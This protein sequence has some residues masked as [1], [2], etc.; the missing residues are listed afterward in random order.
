MGIWSGVKDFFMGKPAEQAPGQFDPSAFGLGSMDFLRQQFQSGAAGAQGRGAPMAGQ[1]QINQGPQGEVRGRE[2]ALADQLTGVSTGQQMGAGELAVR[3]QMAQALAG[4]QAAQRMARGSNAAIGARAAARAAGDMGVNAAGMSAQQALADQAAAR[5]QLGGLLGGIRGADLG[6]ATSQAGLE[7]QTNLANQGASLQ[8]RGMNDALQLG[9]LGG[10]TDAERAQMQG[11]MGL[12]GLRLSPGQQGYLG[13]ILQMGGQL[14]GAAIMMS[15]ERVKENVE[16][17]RAAVREFL[18]K[19]KPATWDYKDP[20]HGQGRHAGVMA[21][22]VEKSKLGKSIVQETPDGKALDGKK[23][24][25]ATLAAA[26]DLNAR[27]SKLESKKKTA[28]PKATAKKRKA[29]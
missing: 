15:D 21:Q 7:Q 25:S 26:V 28:L 16:D 23:L 29:K 13:D 8:Q 10:L 9:M 11:Q 20:K 1:V 2:M 5:G 12:Q 17:G 27:L 18:G 19:L 6:L 14:G 3:R 22:D 4:T 24:L